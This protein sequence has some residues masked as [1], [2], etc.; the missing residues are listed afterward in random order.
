MEPLGNQSVFPCAIQ[1]D[2]VQLMHETP[3]FQLM[4]VGRLGRLDELFLK[5]LECYLILHAVHA[6]SVQVR[7][8]NMVQA[9]T[10]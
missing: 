4:T 2:S 1:S 10:S 8:V 3:S 7:E 5:Q 9:V 6:L